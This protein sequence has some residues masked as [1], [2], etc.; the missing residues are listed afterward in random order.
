MMKRPV[1]AVDVDDVLAVN[2]AHF[3]EF[4]NKQWG[5]NLTAEEFQEDFTKMWGVDTKEVS[6][7]MEE[8]AALGVP[9]DYPHF[10]EAIP[11][12]QKLSKRYDLVI[13]TSRRKL[14]MEHTAVWLNKYFG[15]IF[16][17]V[18]HAGIYDKLH[19]GS[20][21]ATKADLCRQ[22]GSDYLI[23]DQIKHCVAAAEAGIKSVLFG[24]YSW[25]RVADNLPI[26]VVRALDWQ[27]VKEYFD[28]QP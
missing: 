13:V 17:E 10:E 7:R 15:G 18:H 27:A 8:Y 28:A 4:S 22:I 14:L 26:N 1:I 11:V 5:T 6:R 12:L 9:A 21:T 16:K 19:A 20:F 3:V 24:D 2:A 23:D 25:N